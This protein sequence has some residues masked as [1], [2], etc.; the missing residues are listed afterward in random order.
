MIYETSLYAHIWE[1]NYARREGFLAAVNKLNSEIPGRA[2]TGAVLYHSDCPYD[3]RLLLH[4]S[5]NPNFEGIDSIVLSAQEAM[6]PVARLR[7]DITPRNLL[8]ATLNGQLN[9]QTLIPDVAVADPCRIKSLEALERKGYSTI[10]WGTS[11]NRVFL[12]HQ[13]ERKP[14]VSKLQMLLANSEIPTW[15]DAIDIDYGQSI[16]MEIEKGIEQSTA[17]IF[18][19]SPKFLE[20]NWC[21]YE[22]EG[23]L[24]NYASS[25]STT[26]FA[27]IEEGLEQ[28]VPQALT[29]LKYVTANANTNA[30]SIA[31][32]LVPSLRRVL[33]D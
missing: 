10:D 17:V 19:I 30:E 16:V 1:G 21:K 27:V 13:F 9:M 8:I 7:G 18:W 24:H 20:S 11:R 3:L 12:S 25:R 31:A 2:L 4:L 22:F 29:R 33:K 28:K 5:F 32:T 6:G 15:F 14:Q 26:I 23:F